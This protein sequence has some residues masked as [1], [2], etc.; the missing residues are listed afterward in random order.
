VDVVAFFYGCRTLVRMQLRCKQPNNYVAHWRKGPNDYIRVGVMDFHLSK[1]EKIV[2]CPSWV[3]C[4]EVKDDPPPFPNAIPFLK[5]L[6]ILLKEVLSSWVLETMLKNWRHHWVN[7]AG[8]GHG[9]A[10]FLMKY[11]VSGVRQNYI[12]DPDSQW[13]SICM[14]WSLRSVKRK[15]NT[16]SYLPHGRTITKKHTSHPTYLSVKLGR[17]DQ[18]KRVWVGIHVLM[19]IALRGSPPQGDKYEV[20]HTCC[21]AWC[22]NPQHLQWA[23]H[24]QNMAQHMHG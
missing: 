13:E 1:V 12:G 19:C 18:G 10:G 5:W 3:A 22:L 24:A 6:H 15:N 23:T 21:N 8:G 14:P 9:L 4:M 20:S 17:N 2:E 7:F 16:K 11:N